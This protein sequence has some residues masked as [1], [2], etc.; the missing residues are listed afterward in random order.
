MHQ[1]GADR[2][3]EEHAGSSGPLHPEHVA[4]TAALFRLCGSGV[5]EQ[6]GRKL[7]AAG[8]VGAKELAARGKR[9]SR[10]KGRCDSLDR[11]ILPTAEGASEGLP[12][13]CAAGLGSS[14]AFGDPS[15]HTE[16]LGSGPQLIPLV[17]SYAY[18][19]PTTQQAVGVS[20]SY[21]YDYV[22]HTVTATKPSLPARPHNLRQLRPHHPAGAR[23]TGRSDLDG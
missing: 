5:V 19:Q 13:G 4:E 22:N 20:T 21:S 14:Q 17:S 2:A 9:K 18:T 10:A 23:W 3:A 15:T 1:A 8:G 11:G 16:P 7:D 12:I 6:L